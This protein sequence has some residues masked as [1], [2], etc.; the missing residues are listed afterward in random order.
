MVPAVIFEQRFWK[1]ERVY[2][3]KVVSRGKYI[4]TP[5]FECSV[6]FNHQSCYSTVAATATAL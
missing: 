6:D 3:N 2:S 4:K 1:D 5:V